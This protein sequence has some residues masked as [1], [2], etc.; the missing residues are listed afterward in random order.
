MEELDALILAFEKQGQEYEQMN[1]H[2]GQYEYF[3]LSIEA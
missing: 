3:N 1:Q 2:R